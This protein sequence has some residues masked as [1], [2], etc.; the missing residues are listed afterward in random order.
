MNEYFSNDSALITAVLK[1]FKVN[2]LSIEA[3]TGPSTTLYEIQPEMGVRISKIRNLKD[4]IAI[5]LQADS[6]RIIA[7]IPG[8]GTVGIEVSNKVRQIVPIESLLQSPD[9]L[10]TDMQ[11]PLALG[12]TLTGTNLIADL[13]TMPHLLIAGATGQGKSV[14]LNSILLSLINK[15]TPEELRLILIDPKQVEFAPYSALTP[16]LS[17]PIGTNGAVAADAINSSITIME[18]RYTELATHGVR[19][20]QEYNALPDTQKMPYLVLVIDEYGDLIAQTTGLTNGICRLAQKARAVGIHL[21]ISTQRPSVKIVTGDIKANFPVRIA[22][23]M[24]T[25]TDSRVILGKSGAETLTGKGDMLFFNGETTIRAQGTFASTDEV[26][27]TITT[28]ADKYRYNTYPDPIQQLQEERSKAAQLAELRRKEEM[29]YAEKLAFLDRA[30]GFNSPLRK[31]VTNGEISIDDA[32]RK[33]YG[34]V[35]K[36]KKNAKHLPMPLRPLGNPL[37]QLREERNRAKRKEST[38]TTAPAIE[39]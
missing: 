37:Q 31:A 39:P 27:A 18:Q 2:I 1:A 6:V 29:A 13:A 23:R 33:C 9:Y 25:S 4:E 20:I 10:N 17:M 21:I 22:F 24:I 26:N 38:L 35:P 3:T 19:N 36:F 16:Y 8:R 30:C 34:Y 28:I 15:R 7:P 12:T 5:A 11:L 14:C 32:L